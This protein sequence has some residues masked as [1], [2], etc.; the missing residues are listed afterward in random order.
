MGLNFSNFG[1]ASPALFER[2]EFKLRHAIGKIAPKKATAKNGNSGG[3]GG[4][5]VKDCR[6]YR[7]EEY[8]IRMRVDV[9][10]NILPDEALSEK[11]TLGLG[12][13]SQ[14]AIEQIITGYIVEEEIVVGDFVIRTAS[15]AGS[16]VVAVALVGRNNIRAGVL[17]HF[18]VPDMNAGA[19]I[20]VE[21]IRKS[22]VVVH[23]LLD[24][25]AVA[26]VAV[27]GVEESCAID[28]M[29]ID[30]IE[31]VDTSMAQINHRGTGSEQY[32][33]A[34]LLAL[35][36]YSYCTGI[37]S[38]RQIERASH[39]GGAVRFVCANTHPDHDT[40]CTFRRNNGA[41]LQRA[42]AQ[43]LE[44]ATR[45]RTGSSERSTRSERASQFHRRGK[46]YYENQRRLPAMLQHP[47]RSGHRLSFDRRPAREPIAQRQAGT[48]GG[49]ES[50][51]RKCEPRHCARG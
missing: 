11:V 26:S 8:G 50:G 35:L 49:L 28:R 5:F 18:F 19:E 2:A 22:D 36:V 13:S 32:P 41:L 14:D 29:R 48:G 17:F 31:S 30:A 21:D 3:G 16:T 24:E 23:A 1:T 27:A 33:P 20:V 37:F 44:M 12:V 39:T 6:V 51:E 15:N 7:I 9:I 47:S 40:I 4:I 45:S 46:P 10:L 34:M 43:N 42:F 38:S 25:D